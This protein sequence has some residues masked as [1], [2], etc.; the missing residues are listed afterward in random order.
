M[1]GNMEQSQESSLL[2]SEGMMDT[3][4]RGL[5]LKSPE[6]GITGL[7]EFHLSSVPVC[8]HCSD[9]FRVIF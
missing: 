3:Q 1:P 4:A 6:A 9:T 8:C 2:S 5:Q 7:L